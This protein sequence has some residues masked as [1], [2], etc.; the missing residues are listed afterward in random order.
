VTVVPCAGAVVRDSTG[1]LLLV[2]RGRPPAVGRWSLP[3]GRLE[4]GETVAQAVRREVR[5]ETGLDVR[6]GALAGR[7]E[8]P[9]PGGV[10]YA[11]TDHHCQVVGGSVRAGDDAV[12]VLW[13]EPE[14]LAELDLTDGLLETL[15]AW[16]VL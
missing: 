8:R 1:R 15:T 4:K 7:V 13:V 3:G 12:D 10:V 6:V 14:R 16:G 2:R 9:G 5:E 11:I